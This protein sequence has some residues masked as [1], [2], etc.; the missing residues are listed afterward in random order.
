MKKLFKRL[1]DSEF[2]HKYVAPVVKLVISFI[3]AGRPFLDVVVSAGKALWDD[4][5]KDGKFQLNELRWEYIGGLIA[6][7]LLLRFDIIEKTDLIAIAEFILSLLGG[8]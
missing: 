5:N 2:I 1:N 8:E 3:P 4:K 6:V 7:A